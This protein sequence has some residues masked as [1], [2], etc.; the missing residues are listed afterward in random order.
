MRG[1]PPGAAA[2]AAVALRRGG[3]RCVHQGSLRFLG[4]G[5]ILRGVLPPQTKQRENSN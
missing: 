4:E 5:D 2:P 3:E 1:R